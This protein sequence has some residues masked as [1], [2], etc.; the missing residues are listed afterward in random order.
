MN[1]RSFISSAAAL[2]FTA[3]TATDAAPAV[4]RPADPPAPDE[5]DKPPEP[6][7][8]LAE[9]IAEALWPVL[10]ACWTLLVAHSKL[11]PAG[12]CFCDLC[13]EA[14]AL[15]HYAGVSESVISGSL[16][17][18]PAYDRR[19]AT[20]ARQ[21]GDTA[22]AEYWEACVDGDDLRRA[23]ALLKVRSEQ[24]RRPS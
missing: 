15:R 12:P 14:R 19:L 3:P 17:H 4:S 22:H 18:W 6:N 9:A 13:D 20:S 5:W 24:K 21:K 2:A 10:D 16:I 7:D 23:A 8:P 11:E 1:R